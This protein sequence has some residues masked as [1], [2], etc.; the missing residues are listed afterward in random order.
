MIQNRAT[1][2]PFQRRQLPHVSIAMLR[3]FI[4]SRGALVADG[5]GPVVAAT[6][7]LLDPF[8]TTAEPKTIE[9]DLLFPKE[10]ATAQLQM[11]LLPHA[12]DFLR[13]CSATQRRIF[14]FDPNAEYFAEQLTR[15]GI[16]DLFE[17]F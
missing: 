9:S 15:I 12:L 8:C 1:F 11:R 4:F 10:F 5:A 17:E 14:F 2:S 16:A 7:L 13:F 3:N 6:T